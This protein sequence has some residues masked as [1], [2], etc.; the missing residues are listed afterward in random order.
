M[1]F[2]SPSLFVRLL[3]LF[4]FVR[5][6]VID[7]T[8]RVITVTKRSFWFKRSQEVIPFSG[9]KYIQYEYE[10][11]LQLTRAASSGPR[12]STSAWR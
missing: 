9:V 1:T 7:P 3:F 12:P 2:T 11:P 6:T 8:A 5:R 4:A 10:K